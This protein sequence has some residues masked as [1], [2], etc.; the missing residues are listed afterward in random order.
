M[1]IGI[2]CNDSGGAEILSSYIKN[3][4]KN[5]YVFFITG[6]A[7]KIFKSK[8]KFKNEKKINDLVYKSELIICGTSRKSLTERNCI[9][10]AKKKGK[11]TISLIDHWVNYSSRF[12][13]NNIKILPNEIWVTDR[14]AFN[15]A[16]KEF[17]NLPIKLIRNYY[18]DSFK[19]I[20]KRKNKKQKNNFLYICDPKIKKIVGYSEKEAFT[21]FL[22]KLI[23]RNKINKKLI[24]V[25]PHPSQRKNSF[26]NFVKKNKINI[27]K[28]KSLLEDILLHKNIVG[29]GSMALV[30]A[31]KLKKKVFCAMPN[32]GRSFIP[33]IKNLVFLSK[34]K[35]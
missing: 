3:N 28:N 33:K 27:S 26:L 20:L 31:S 8:L 30:V 32:H 16:K 11:K 21:L 18:L 17:K 5:N 1:K 24:C 13:R 9:I 29:C 14:L 25:R 6:P 15:I 10:L 12:V 2:V 34:F 19:K 35:N 22:N 4:K 23:V 7:I